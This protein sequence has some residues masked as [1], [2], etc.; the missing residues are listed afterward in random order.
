MVDDVWECVRDSRVRKGLALAG[1]S[2]LS[3]TCN[4]P[5]LGVAYC[6]AWAQL[7]DACYSTLVSGPSHIYNFG[8]RQRGWHLD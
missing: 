2:N 7:T 3:G 8:R 4:A 6:L 5:L 1:V